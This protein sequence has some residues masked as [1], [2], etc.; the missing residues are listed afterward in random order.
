MS[1]HLKDP[2]DVLDYEHDWTPWLGGDTIAT[3][4]WTPPDGITVDSDTHTDTTATVWISGGEAGK[5]YR[6]TNHIT[7]TG[8]RTVER[9]LPIRVQD[10]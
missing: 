4:A 5:S 2:A 10:R 1:A 8:G 7:T 9:S 6:I 3:S